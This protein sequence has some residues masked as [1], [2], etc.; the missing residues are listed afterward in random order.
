MC[1]FT[2]QCLAKPESELYDFALQVGVYSGI[3]SFMR[4]TPP[5]SVQPLGH[6]R[7]I[8]N[9][10]RV[11]YFFNA[12]FV[13]GSRDYGQVEGITREGAWAPPL[14]ISGVAPLFF[15]LTMCSFNKL[16]EIR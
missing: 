9:D 15:V 2:T 3:L 13:S 7:I 10:Y 12:E 8:H 14:A 16:V 5:M 1:R 6:A 4:A 11:N